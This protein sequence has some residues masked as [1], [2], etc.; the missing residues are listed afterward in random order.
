[1]KELHIE[2]AGAGKTYGIAQRM[3][4]MLRQCPK[5]KR[6]F[7]ITY[8]NYA[9][10][11]IRLEIMNQ[12]HY[13]PDEI[14][15]D[16]V[17][18]FMLEQIVY[19]FSKFVKSTPIQSC[20]IE[21]LSSN[22]KWAAKR[23]FELRQQGIIHSDATIQFAKSLLVP[24]SGDNKKLL[25]LKEIAMQY[26]LSNIFCLFVDEAQDMNGDFFN[27]MD[28]II[29]R[30]ENYCFVGDPNQD[31]WGNYHYKDFINSVICTYGIEPILNLIS[32]RL[33][34]SVIPLCNSIM[35]SDFQITSCNLVHGEVGYVLA[36]ELCATE[37]V[38][39]SKSD[40]FSI[41]KCCSGVFSTRSNA[42]V[43]IPYEFKEILKSKFPN[44]DID[45]LIFAFTKRA[46]QI[47]L[48][49]VLKEYKITIEK[50]IYAKL[51]QQLEAP[52]K[53]NIQ[54]CSI[55]KAKGLESDTVFFIICN[56]LLEILLGLKNDH[57][58]ET[59]LLYVALTRTKLKLLLIVEDDFS[60]QSTLKKHGIDLRKSLNDLGICEACK[61]DWFP[62]S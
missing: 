5:G 59:N 39:L 17:H 52:D 61:A 46:L 23:R 25:K 56:S 48:T 11:Q 38:F 37:R 6:I 10:S 31:L 4:C 43:Q 29:T 16:T 35:N 13:L 45:A 41:I 20:S 24:A 22:I 32:R 42:A 14:S 36:S 44:Y 27:L 21:V 15:I 34:Q 18:G 3:I 60:T 19:P 57:N 30:L 26:F 55:H 54:V 8:T 1:M 47:G 7:A 53:N 51:S 40:T 62:A 49:P 2:C 58:K 28:L 50:E 12:L 33:P 9:V